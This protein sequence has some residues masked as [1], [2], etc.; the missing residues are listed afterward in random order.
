MSETFEPTF[1]KD[2]VTIIDKEYYGGKYKRVFNVEITKPEGKQKAILKLPRIYKANSNDTRLTDPEILQLNEEAQDL[3]KLKMLIPAHVPAYLGKYESKVRNGT[4]VE[5]VEGE[6]IADRQGNILRKPTPEQWNRFENSLTSLSDQG[7][8][9][10]LDTVLLHNLMLGK[11]PGS[12]D[13]EI[14]LI[15]PMILE[16]K[17]ENEKEMYG[18]F[19]LQGLKSDSKV[20]YPQP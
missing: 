19:M 3:R 13:E 8:F 10:D 2:N 17:S 11:L 15:E 12:E 4:L 1:T 6:M 9:L 18:R 5:P 16:A 7:V 20:L 14:I